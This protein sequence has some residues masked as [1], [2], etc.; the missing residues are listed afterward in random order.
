VKG[1]I[2]FNSRIPMIPSDLPFSFKRL[3]FPVKV[4]F[5]ITINKAQGQTFKYVGVDLCTE[6]FSHGQ[7]YVAFSR[8]GDPNH[9][10]ILISTGNTTKNIIYSEVL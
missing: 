2:A 5:A 1:E 9:L 8:T 7:L 10:M 3:Q 6:W 4:S